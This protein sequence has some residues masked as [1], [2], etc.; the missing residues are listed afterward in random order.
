MKKMIDRL[1]DDIQAKKSPIVVGLDP[2]ISRIPEVYFRN[3]QGENEL[4]IISNAIVSSNKDILDSISDLVPM[5]KPQ[6]AFYEMLKHYGIQAFEET[7]EYAKAKGLIVI[8]DGK[9]NDIGNTAMAYAQGHLGEFKGINCKLK[10]FDVDFLTISPYLGPESLDPFINV[11]EEY[12]KGVFI[13]VKTSN[14]GNS[15]IQDVVTKEG[16]TISET[17]AAY[18]QHK[19]MANR[20][21]YGYSAIG[22]VVG[23]TYPEDAKKLRKLMPNS[24]FLVPGY[25]AQGGSAEDIVACFNDDG[26][27]AVISSSRGILYGYEKWIDAGSCTTSKYKEYVRKLTIEMQKE[28]YTSL[29]AH[30]KNMRY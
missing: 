17:I 7:V 25:G 15:I 19:S 24:L 14:P 6:I 29:K 2:V 5:V 3:A 26:L 1:I 28:I 20:G 9:R 18:V 16:H 4:E 8:E 13:L 22:A 30:C 12:D 27:G 21:D 11:C 10:G 23:A